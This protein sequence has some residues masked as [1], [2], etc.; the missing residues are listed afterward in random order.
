MLS[1]RCEL[2]TK[3]EYFIDFF[4]T[5]IYKFFCGPTRSFYIRKEQ[6]F[7]PFHILQLVES[8]PFIFLKPEKGTLFEWPARIG[9]YVVFKN[10]SGL[11]IN[12]S[13]NEEIWIVSSEGKIQDLFGI[14]WPDEPIRTLN[15]VISCTLMTSNFC[16][17]KKRNYEIGQSQINDG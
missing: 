3:P 5:A 1:S 8:A 2:I 10:L 16:T 4:T 15:W 13:K 17:H 14:K 12:S 7:L 9:H 6:I 11:V